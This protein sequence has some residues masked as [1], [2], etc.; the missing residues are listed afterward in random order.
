MALSDSEKEIFDSLVGGLY[1]EDASTL[2]AN[3]ATRKIVLYVILLLL[4]VA[5]LIVGVITKII[6]FGIAGFCLMVYPV[7]RAGL[8]SFKTW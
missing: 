3:I 7:Y 4:G 6:F 8:K 1:D 5:L 2:E